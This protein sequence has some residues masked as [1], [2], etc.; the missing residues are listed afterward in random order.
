M[1][2][3]QH[4]WDYLIYN[5]YCSE[6]TLVVATKLNGYSEKTLLDVLYALTGYRSLDQVPDGT[7]I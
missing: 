3:K 2:D 5:G 6:E 1:K 7:Q 4:I